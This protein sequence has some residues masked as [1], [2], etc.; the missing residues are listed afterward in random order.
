MSVSGA[1]GLAGGSAIPQ[2]EDLSPAAR[3]AHAEMAAARGEGPDLV[4]FDQAWNVDDAA[5]R[6][7]LDGT[8]DLADVVVLVREAKDL[9]GIN[10][11]EHDALARLLREDADLFTQDAYEA[12]AAYM[13]VAVPPFERPVPSAEPDASPPAAAPVDT[14][15]AFDPAAMP[16]VRL[17]SH[18]APVRTLQRALNDWRSQQGLPALSVDGA[19][20]GGTRRAVMAFQRANGLGADGVVGRRTWQ[21]L[22]RFAAPIEVVTRAPETFAA[23]APGPQTAATRA[24]AAHWTAVP[25]QTSVTTMAGNG[26]RPVAVHTGPGFDPQKPAKIVTF[27]HG[28][29]WNI[30]ARFKREGVLDRVRTLQQQDPQTV[31]VFPEAARPPFS[32]WLRPP[33]ESLGSL[34]RE[35]VGVA[36]TLAGASSLVVEKRTIGAHS[37]AGLALVN[38]ARSGELVADKINLLDS[39]YGSWSQTI[40]RWALRQS[41]PPRIESWYTLHASQARNNRAIQRIA[42]RLVTTHRVGSGSLHNRV[43]GRYFGTP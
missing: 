43:P 12:L 6:V 39:A 27:L 40:A 22:A 7:R 11:D 25:G 37:G 41:P 33:R 20:G 42:P 31:F 38:A 9:G 28:H 36:A 18:G 3:G 5:M 19:F 14:R 34:T 21:M 2:L 32:Y 8:I 17:R 23:Q 30:G 15:P 26:G 35:A 13:H 4:V 1:S 16:L 10:A 29:R 24:I